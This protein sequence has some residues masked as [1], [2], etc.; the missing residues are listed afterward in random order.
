MS[1]SN[2]K[3]NTPKPGLLIVGPGAMGSVLG[4]FL[5][6]SFDVFFVDHS[7]AINHA[8]EI[9]IDNRT[10]KYNFPQA[11]PDD[12][13]RCTVALFAVKAF[14]LEQA[15]E[16]HLPKLPVGACAISL[17]NGFVEPVIKLMSEKYSNLKIRL[18]YCNF[19]VSTDSGKYLF[20]SK[21][22][23]RLFWGPNKEGQ[24][25]KS[26]E[27]LN[28]NSY[29]EWCDDIITSARS[30]WV[31]NTV[32]NGLT[33]AHRMASNGEALKQ[34]PALQ[35]LFNEAWDLAI[36]LFNGIDHDKGEVWL[37]L[38]SLIQDT[39]ENENSMARDVRLGLQTESDYLAGLANNFGDKYPG[40]NQIHKRSTL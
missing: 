26:E 21:G 7:G 36:D 13:S 6:K 15:F 9:E 37:G 1:D 18:G 23:G 8:P 31:Y 22:S 11:T 27:L 16:N 40:L 35:G 2:L 4:A 5:Q 38:L 29:C 14:A 19:G 12:L 34:K 3:L 25:T 39:A 33:A 17:S 30:K 32:L 28:Q 24:L 10:K 20:R